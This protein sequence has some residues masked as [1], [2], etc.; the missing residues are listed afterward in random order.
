MSIYKEWPTLNYEQAKETYQTIHL[1]TQIIGKIKLKKL[2]W[3]NHS[4]HIALIVT[5]TGISSSYIP[6]EKKHFQ[7]DLDF[8]EHQLKVHT[9][10]GERKAFSLKNISVADFYYK[11]MGVL[12]ELEI[13]V[14]I[15]VKPN[16]IVDPILF[17]KDHQHASYE[18][19]HVKAI[20][21]AFLQSQRVLTQFRA[22][23]KGKCSPIHLFWGSFD[24][25][26]SR[27]SGERAPKH[28]GGVPNLPDPVAVEA[29]S[30]EVASCGF[31]PGNDTLPYA[32]FYAYHY[33]APDGYKDAKVKPDEAFFHPDLGEFILPYKAVQEAADPV[34]KLLDFLHSTYNAGASLAHWNRAAFEDVI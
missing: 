32:A 21:K 34:V 31:W 13:T 16:E 6:D 3:V 11:L 10:I 7:I 25:A 14:K 28:P 24:L 9:D 20:H 1:W 5:P 15:N 8:C 22:E 18:V 4:W 19:I 33:P 30:H 17:T 2:P 27:F 12:T 23:F 26:V 29:Y